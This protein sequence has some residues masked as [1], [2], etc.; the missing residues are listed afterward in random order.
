MKL[1][2]IELMVLFGVAVSPFWFLASNLKDWDEVVKTGVS[3]LLAPSSFVLWRTVIKN[4]YSEFWR[5]LTT[6]QSSLY[7][8][9]AWTKL[10]SRVV[11]AKPELGE[12]EVAQIL[13]W[14]TELQP[15]AKPEPLLVLED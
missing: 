9:L 7:W 4:K 15:E 1:S 10:E 13:T 14:M 8:E 5:R 3:T 12:E 2:K 11:A 6:D